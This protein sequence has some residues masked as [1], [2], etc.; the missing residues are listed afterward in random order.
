MDQIRQIG[1]AYHHQRSK[2]LVQFRASGLY[3]PIFGVVGYDVDGDLRCAQVLYIGLVGVVT[4]REDL[5]LIE[6]RSRGS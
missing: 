6:S 4:V 2:L 5:R 3:R 1:R